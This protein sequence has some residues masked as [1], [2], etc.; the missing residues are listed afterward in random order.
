MSKRSSHT[1]LFNTCT[2][3][4]NF[5]FEIVITV[6]TSFETS[7]N[8]AK[9]VQLE[10]FPFPR[11]MHR[12]HLGRHSFGGASQ[13]PGIYITH[14]ERWQDERLWIYRGLWEKLHDQCSY[15]WSSPWSN[16]RHLQKCHM[17]RISFQ[18]Q[19]RLT[20]WTMPS[21]CGHAEGLIQKQVWRNTPPVIIDWEMMR[22]EVV[23]THKNV[24]VCCTCHIGCQ[25][26]HLC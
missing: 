19:S 20:E 12:V 13:A 7:H 18:S 17:L 26:W 14:C 6:L 2:Q 4:H 15:S 21:K 22:E 11:S 8:R 1:H 25:K 24:F 3:V 16:L 9:Y 23:M 10:G 5:D